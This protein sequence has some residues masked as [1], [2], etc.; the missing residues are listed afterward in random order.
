[1]HATRRAAHGSMRFPS[2]ERFHQY[3]VSKRRAYLRQLFD[4]RSTRGFFDLW[5]GEYDFALSRFEIAGLRVEQAAQHGREI[6]WLLMQDLHQVVR[7]VVPDFPP[8]PPS[9][10]AALATALHQTRA[11]RSM[12]IAGE[13][14]TGKEQLAALLHV[15]AGRPGALVRLAAAELHG[16]AGTPTRQMM[17]E[18]GSVFI[19]DLEQ[20]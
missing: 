7:S 16:K 14:G 17:P 20:L 10:V 6:H 15:L 5:K 18:R 11:A 19:G 12:L 4:K 13:A 3:C 2:V 8:A 9:V 1:M